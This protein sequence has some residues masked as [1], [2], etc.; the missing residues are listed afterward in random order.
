MASKYLQKFP[1][2][3]GFPQILHDFTKEILRDQPRDIIE[4]GYM[5]FKA[6]EQ[7]RSFKVNL[8]ERS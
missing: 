3:N 7:V 1:I 4:F 6:L 5:Y 2:P 8:R